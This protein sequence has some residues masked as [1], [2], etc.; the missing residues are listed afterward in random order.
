M[1][2]AAPLSS[3]GREEQGEWGGREEGKRGG[4]GGREGRTTSVDPS[5]CNH[6]IYSTTPS[7]KFVSC[8][9]CFGRCLVHTSPG[10]SMNSLCI[11]VG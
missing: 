11:L 10:E 7:Y 1:L 4:K 5:S 2:I 6:F 8:E 9:E 3:V